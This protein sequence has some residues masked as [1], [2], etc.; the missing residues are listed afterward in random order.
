M[1]RRQIVE[2]LEKSERQK[3]RATLGSLKSLVLRLA[4]ITRYQKAFQCFI[5]YLKSCHLDIS[6]TK[7]GLDQ[8]LVDYLEFL[9]EDGESLSLAGDTLSSIQYYQPS[10]KRNINQAWKMLKTW[11]LHE[12]PAR[13]TP[14]TWTT[15]QVVLGYTHS[16]SPQTSLGLLLAFKCLLRTGELLGVTN[17]DIIVSPDQS[18]ILVRL[19]LTKTAS[20][21]P[22]SG[23]VHVIDTVLARLLSE[24][25]NQVA[26]DAPLIPFSASKF[27]IFFQQVLSA[28]GLQDL[29][30]K[31][32]SLR[33]GGAT[34]MWIS[35]HSY[36][37][38][39]H[40]GRW[41]SERVMKQYIDDSTALLSNMRV[42]LS[43]KQRSFITLWQ[44]IS[45]VEPPA[46]WQSR[47]RGRKRTR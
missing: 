37:L 19:G 16:I 18:S 3:R 5:S 12:L 36:N 35:T 33:R 43:P 9:W 26:W 42:T 46:S 2:G 10:A 38:V 15:L 39:Q 45:H 17:K 30:L 32:Y 20:R 11:Q 24:W 21:N 29:N 23:T 34:D 41:T 4:T 47:G 25:Q 27:R 28:C 6:S 13:A 40:T 22:S 44:K 7:S 31:P 8:Q 1:G 14:F